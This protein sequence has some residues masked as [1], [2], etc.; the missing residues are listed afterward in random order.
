MIAFG[1][2]PMGQLPVLIPVK[3]LH[4]AKSSFSSTLENEKREN[5]VLAML[6]DVIGAVSQ[7][8]DV[9]PVVVSPD[10]KVLCYARAI[11]AS[12]LRDLGT[13]LNK[14][15]MFAI[16]KVASN[17]ERVLIIP[18]DLPLVRARDIMKIM[19]LSEPRSI[20]ISPSKSDGTNA[21]LL[22][23]PDVIELRFGEESFPCHLQEASRKGV[24]PII[25]RSSTV[26]FDVD[27]PEDLGHVLVNGIGTK[28]Y[29]FLLSLKGTADTSQASRIQKTPGRLHSR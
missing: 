10:E 3:F 7:A 8:S 29:D 23:P 17:E 14:A 12:T 22:R 21:L 9:H 19:E 2:A 15:L 16:K 13:D 11:G 28:T 5:L 4:L 26:E 18:A 27:E 25:Y 1:G 6:A 20:V 24:K